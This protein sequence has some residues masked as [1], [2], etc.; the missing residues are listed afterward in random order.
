MIRLALMGRRT[1]IPALV[2]SW[3]ADFR[4][5]RVPVRDFMKTETLQE[6]LGAYQDRLKTG[7]RNPAAAYELALRSARPYQPGDQISYYVAGDGLSI[8]VNEA[9]KLAAVWDPDAPDEN[10]AYYLDKLRDLYAR[11]RPLVEC[12][13]LVAAVAEPESRP[14]EP[15]RQGD[16]FAG[17]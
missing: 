6:S 11:F 14:V 10:V 2:A 17:F 7:R 5:H 16:L 1:E 12:D 13:G 9:A 3:E 8:K 15:P 4:A